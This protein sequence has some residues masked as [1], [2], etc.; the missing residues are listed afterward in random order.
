[1]SSRSRTRSTLRNTRGSSG[2]TK[3]SSTGSSARSE[4]TSCA[5]PGGNLTG[6]NFLAIELAAKR[7]EFLRELVPGAARVAVASSDPGSMPRNGTR[8]PHFR[9]RG[10]R[11]KPR[12]AE[13][14]YVISGRRTGQSF[15][16]YLSARQLDHLA[17]LLDFLRNEP[18][19]VGRRA[20]S[21]VPPTSAIRAIVLGSARA[22]VSSVLSRSTT[23]VGAPFGAPTPYQALAS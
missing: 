10:L 17:P 22:A 12:D 21:G 13:Q 14:S 4:S 2:D 3:T 20:G 11:R 8:L 1:M 5:R 6:N 7:L 15:C 9:W 19:E 16:L 18:A 23:S